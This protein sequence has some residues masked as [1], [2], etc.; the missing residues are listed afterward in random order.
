[1]RLRDRIWRAALAAYIA[2]TVGWVIG[3]G[4]GE[5]VCQQERIKHFRDIGP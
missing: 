4:C 1:M 3:H 2:A 5:W